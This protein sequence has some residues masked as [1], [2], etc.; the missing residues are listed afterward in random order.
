MRQALSGIVSK[1]ASPLKTIM[2]LAMAMTFVVADAASSLAA[3]SAAIVVDAKTGKVLYSANA[4]G[5]RYPA[6]LTKMM[7]LYLTFEAMA[8]GKIS[9]NSPV[10]F[11]AHASAEAPT[12][13]GVKPGGSVTVETAILSIVT[14]SA[15]DSATALGE[16]IG[17]NETNFARMMTAKARQLGMDGTVFRNANGLPDPGQFTTARDMATLGIALREH[18]PQYYGYFAQRSFLYGRQRINGHNRLLG[19]IKGVDGIKTGYTRASGFNLVSSVNDGNRRLVAVVMG[20]TSGGSRDNQM[21]GLIN[22]YLPRASTRGGGDLVA[23]ADSNPIKAL[24]KVLLPKHDA[25]TPDEK[26]VAVAEADT[27]VADHTTTAV[28][29]DATVAQGDSEDEDTA[30]AEAPKLVVPAKKVKTVIV[31]APKVATAQVVAA[32]AEPAPAAVDPV[33][34]ASVPSGWAIQVASSPNQSEAQAFLDKTTKQAPKVLADASGFTAAFD[35]GGVTYYRVRFGGFGS[36]D[37]AWKACTALK[38]KKIECY[39]VQQ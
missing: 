34:T 3:K 4:D 39:A 5:R 33:S 28:A 13:L 26:P 9:R 25:P 12:K 38:K 2:I 21:A 20:G 18:F 36:K 10:V 7:T 24:A 16:M 30:E 19:R 11:S 37:A 1:S 17:G 35:K 8:K 23:K 22:T 15:N 14:K 31:S 6:S 29:D 27:A 32:Y